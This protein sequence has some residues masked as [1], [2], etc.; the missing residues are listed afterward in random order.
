[1]S[2]DVD[3]IPQE[4]KPEIPAVKRDEGKAIKKANLT[5]TRER[6]EA[7]AELARLQKAQEDAT[8]SSNEKAAKELAAAQAEAAAVKAELASQKLLVDRTMKVAHMVAKH[9]LADPSYGELILQGYKPD[10]HEDFDQ[11][12]VEQ[13][14]IPKF[15][16]LFDTGSSTGDRILDDDGNEIIP[17]TRVGGSGARSKGSNWEDKEAEVAAGLFPYDKARQARYLAEV[18]KLRGG[19]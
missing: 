17:S 15:A 12:V 4:D 9:K 11:F 14:K 16:R 10:E 3:P 2:K 5:L 7:R 8:L 19:K 18:R 6:D 13:A 1:M